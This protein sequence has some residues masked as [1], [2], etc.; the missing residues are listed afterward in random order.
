M[1]ITLHGPDWPSVRALRESLA[2]APETGEFT[3]GGP[4]YAATEQL[5][6]FQAAGVRTVEFTHN[7]AEAEAWVR[8]GHTVFGRRENHTHGSDI[9]GAGGGIRPGPRWRNRDWWTKLVPSVDEWRVHVFAG[10]SIARGKK[11]LTGPTV[12]Q[13]PI[14]SRRN[15]WTMSHTERAP[16]A[17]RNAAKAAVAALEGYLYGAV[18][19]LVTADDTPI[20]LEVNRVPG[21]DGYTVEKYTES[22]R[23]YVA[24]NQRGRVE[25][26]PVRRRGPQRAEGF[27]EGYEVV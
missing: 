16:E 19:L 9:V 21:M 14:R 22:I 25:P 5:A 12:S 23:Q 10:S 24:S 20:V 18:D 6:R 17:V 27:Y 2:S 8:A 1:S 13:W 7:R 26:A 3:L 11:V 15:G 4:R